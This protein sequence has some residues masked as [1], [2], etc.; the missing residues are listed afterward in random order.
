MERGALLY[1]TQVGKEVLVCELFDTKGIVR[2]PENTD[3]DLAQ[4]Q[5]NPT[6]YWLT[7][8]QPSW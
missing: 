2:L 8:S 5:D 6:F 7:R 3:H 4:L 1:T